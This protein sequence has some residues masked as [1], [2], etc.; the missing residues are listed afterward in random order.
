MKQAKYFGKVCMTTY[1]CGAMET[2]PD[3]G[4]GWREEYQEALEA[5]GINCINPTHLE[6]GVGTVQ[7]MID[8]KTT[9]PI[10][11]KKRMRE[12]LYV[13]LSG[14]LNSNFLVCRYEGERVAGTIGELQEAFLENKPNYIVTS[15]PFDQ[16]PGWMIACSTEIFPNLGCL[17]H[18][19]KKEYKL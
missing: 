16:L 1:L 6:A 15:L 3:W 18:F 2:V 9:D 11:Y 7:E 4:V 14:V 5:L 10:E 13:D 17:I 19:L 12:I 8:L